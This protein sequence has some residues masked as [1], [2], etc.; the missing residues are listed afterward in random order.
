MGKLGNIKSKLKKLSV[1]FFLII[2]QGLGYIRSWLPSK[3]ER[4]GVVIGLVTSL[5][6]SWF[7]ASYY[8]KLENREFN[9]L[10]KDS[11][12]TM[13][14]QVTGT[15]TNMTKKST[16]EIVEALVPD[17][18]SLVINNNNYTPGSTCEISTKTREIEPYFTIMNNSKYPAKDITVAILLD[19]NTIEEGMQALDE[20]FNQN[21]A[22]QILEKD[23]FEYENMH[24]EGKGFVI[25]SPIYPSKGRNIR[26][27]KLKMIKDETTIFIRIN[28]KH[29]FYITYRLIPE[30]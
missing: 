12:D 30:K 19:T 21:G 14:Q 20:C 15:V 27:L 4:R 23:S 2:K 13:I 7:V 10:M 5:L 29:S 26:A 9:G 18:F 8:H 3:S 11:T 1:K 28:G 22:F 17:N 24:F 16:E 25:P 6:V